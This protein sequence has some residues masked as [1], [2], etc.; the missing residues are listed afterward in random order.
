MWK[1]A[2]ITPVGKIKNPEKES[3]FRPISVTSVLS[4]KLEP[5]VL[6]QFLYPVMHNSHSDI[7]FSDQYA[8]RP[9]GSTT[10]AIIAVMDKVTELLDTGEVVIMLTL[11][12]SKAFDMVRHK[13][14]FDKFSKLDIN[15]KI[16]NWLTSYFEGRD[17]TTKFKGHISEKKTINA[18]VVQGS[19]LGPYS[20]SVAASD[21]KPKNSGFY[22]FKFADDMDIVTTADKYYLVDNELEH[23]EKWAIDNNMILNKTKTKEIIFRRNRS[24]FSQVALTNGVQRTGSIKMLG[25]TFQDNLSV[26]EHVDATLAK[27]FNGLYALNILRS[28]GLST[29][30]LFQVFQ[31]KILSKLTY[32]APAWWGFASVRDITRINCFLKKAKKM[33]FYPLDGLMIEELWRQSDD[34]LFKSITTNDKHVLYKF[35]PEVKNTGHNLRKRVHLY[36]LPDKDDRN[37]FNRLLYLGIV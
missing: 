22:M 29:E 31:A 30:C 27:C 1:S 6:N 32:A 4:R 2:V 20:Y 18:S 9:T 37:F 13:T 7:S 19:T 8:F 36:N 14:M 21:L 23:I 24:R 17:H 35:L 11:D 25:V 26:G 12:F 3:D 34:K 28:Q 16:Y 15:D 33:K 10:A 5:Y